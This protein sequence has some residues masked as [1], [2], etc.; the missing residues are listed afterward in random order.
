MRHR[1]QPDAAAAARKAAELSV[2]LGA[3]LHLI[4]AYG[5]VESETVEVGSER[6][7]LSTDM[8]ADRVVGAVAVELRQEFPGLEVIALVL[9]G[10]PR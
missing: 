8:E 7:F 4:S 2:A 10:S 1:Q 5:K 3:T 6:I 9:R